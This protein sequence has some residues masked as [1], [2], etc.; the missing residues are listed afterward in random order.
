MVILEHNRKFGASDVGGVVAGFVGRATSRD[1]KK[2][3]GKQ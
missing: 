2:D 3:E 1:K